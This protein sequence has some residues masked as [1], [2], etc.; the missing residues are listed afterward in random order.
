MTKFLSIRFVTVAA[1]A[2]TGVAAACGAVG[3]GHLLQVEPHS[4]HSTDRVCFLLG[5]AATAGGS[6]LCAA[7]AAIDEH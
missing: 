7:G 2:I 4:E 6:L 5:L 1:F 3:A